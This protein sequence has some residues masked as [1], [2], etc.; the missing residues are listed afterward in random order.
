MQ[1]L[2]ASWSGDSK[3]QEIWDSTCVIS[4]L[5]E[6]LIEKQLI[7]EYWKERDIN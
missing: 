6:D 7:T 2:S 4:E 3:V 1:L 5:T